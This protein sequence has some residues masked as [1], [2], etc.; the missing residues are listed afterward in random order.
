MKSNF[1]VL[2]W[3]RGVRDALAAETAGMNADASLKH[4]RQTADDAVRTFL[5]NHPDVG[6]S[7]GRHLPSVA[8]DRGQ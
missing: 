3:L 8:E 5:K 1:K 6:R 2:E 4:D 7:E